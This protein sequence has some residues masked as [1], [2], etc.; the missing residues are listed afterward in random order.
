MRNLL[1]EFFFY[2]IRNI[3]RIYSR[4]FVINVKYDTKI[5]SNGTPNVV[6]GITN[7]PV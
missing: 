6:C 3:Q 1:S 5:F 4:G 2:F 7:G